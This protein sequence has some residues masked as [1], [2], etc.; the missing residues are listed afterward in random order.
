MLR[1]GDLAPLAEAG[2]RPDFFLDEDNR[3]VY[4]SVLRYKAEYGDVPTVAMM[5][6]DFPQYDFARASEPMDYLVKEVRDRHVLMLVQEGIDE[7]SEHYSRR[8]ASGAV[9][10]LQRIISQATEDT[11]TTR[12]VDY[13]STGQQ[14]WE[15]YES[16]RDLPDGLRGIPTGFDTLDRATQG[17]QAEQ[18]V[19]LVGPPKAGKSTLM[20]LTALAA[21]RYGKRPLLFTFEM[22]TDEIEE[23]LDAI[24]AEISHSR[25]RGGALKGDEKARLKKYLD[26][27]E[28][29]PTF[30]LSA[31][32][33][34]ATTLTGISAKVDVVKPDILFVDG[35]Y[36]LD[37]E[38]GEAKGSPQALTNLT[39][40]FK[41]LAQNKQIPIVI[42]TQVLY[43]RMK[44]SGITA[45]SIGYSSSF[46]QDSDVILGVEPTDEPAVNR[47]RI[48][49]ARNAPPLSKKV[50]WDWETG[51]FQELDHDEEPDDF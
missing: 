27:V 6:A 43:S 2:I 46:A 33:S 29:M 22:S 12:D 23:R 21:H 7:S 30:I 34:S 47:L 9:A 48:V 41:R 5:R 18:L 1:E 50:T 38:N 20:V 17:L 24:S 51:K 13:T 42:S 28:D 15:R 39:R 19:T 11:P 44:K 14:R 26:N 31:D 45:D 4:E 3:R 37:D 16:L 40:G 8:D 49:A 25:L 32:T 35:V 10:A 36:L